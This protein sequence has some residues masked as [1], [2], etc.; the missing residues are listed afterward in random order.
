M[1]NSITKLG[2]L[3]WV[4]Q[5]EQKSGS[6]WNG[7]PSSYMFQLLYLALGVEERDTKGIGLFEAQNCG[8]AW[9]NMYLLCIPNWL[10]IVASTVIL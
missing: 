7:A 9:V 5:R 2:Y 8:R 3:M 4:Q 10:F 1:G 6:W